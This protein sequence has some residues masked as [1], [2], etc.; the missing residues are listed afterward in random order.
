MYLTEVLTKTKKGK[1]SHR[2]ILLRESHRENGKVK[3]KTI[4]NITHCKPEEIEAIKLALKYKDNLSVLKSVKED[5]K[6]KSGLSIGS[7]YL[8]YDI[9]KRIGI[10]KALGKDKFGK[11]AMY[12]IIGRLLNQGSRLSLTRLASTHSVCD[13]LGIREGFNE[14]HLYSN[15]DWLS[16]NQLKI[17]KRLFNERIKNNEKDNSVLDLFLYDVTSSYF[18]GGEFEL[19]DFGYNRDGKKGKKQVVVGLLCD[20]KGDPVS[21]EVFTG[22]TRDFDTVDNQINKAKKEFNCKSV[23]FVGDRGMIKSDQID[24]LKN[25][26]F[27]HI[28]AITKP[29]INKLLNMGIFNMSLFDEDLNEINFEGERYILRRNPYRIEEIKRNREEKKDAVIKLINKKN[30]YLLNHKRADVSV[31]LNKI[32]E[33]IEKLRISNW[34]KAT[35]EG[36]EIYLVEDKEALK[37]DEKLYGCYVIKTNLPKEYNKEFIHEKYKDLFLVEQAFR[38]SKR[39]FLEMQPWFVRT[40]ESTRGHAFIVMLS[41]LI[42]KYLKKAWIDIN[43]TVEEGINELSHLCLMEVELD[44]GTKFQKIPEPNKIQKLLLDSAGVKLPEIIPHFDVTVVSRKKL[45]RDKE[46]H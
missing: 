40:E 28:T 13:V 44:N 25:A 22:N 21:V 46:K 18:E 36:R 45:K 12:Q 34:L 20:N 42:V 7:T 11:L 23:T 2:C 15:L 9:A 29:E 35:N 31:A 32:N 8:I 37:E 26:G 39:D 43:L 27:N 5:I 14:E 19:S 3:T 16:K 1:I 33:K 41:Y 17:E 6:I 24:S 30:D 38:T 10:E 4:A